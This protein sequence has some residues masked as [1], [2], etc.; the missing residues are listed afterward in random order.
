MV[1]LFVCFCLFCF[2]VCLF[3]CLFCIE[4][5][6]LL[7][8]SLF[9]FFN[10]HCSLKFY[11][12]EVYSKAL[13]NLILL[14]VKIWKNLLRLSYIQIQ[15]DKKLTIDIL[16]IHFSCKRFKFFS[17]KI[18]YVTLPQNLFCIRYF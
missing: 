8:L 6:F 16:Y 17:Q 4:S 5:H 1:S 15:C 18:T 14:R 12:F 10:L 7:R 3:V 2:F 13:E 11:K 9:I